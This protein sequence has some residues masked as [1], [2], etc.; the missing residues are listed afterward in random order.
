MQRE[1]LVNFHSYIRMHI[2]TMIKYYFQLFID[3][4]LGIL[5]PN[6]MSC[7]NIRIYNIHDNN[8]IFINGFSV[9]LLF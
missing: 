7:I 4:I 1:G 2:F 3:T 6:E 8:F 5:R 9:K